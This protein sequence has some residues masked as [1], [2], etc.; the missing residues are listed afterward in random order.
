[1]S[2]TLL[3]GGKLVPYTSCLAIAHGVV[4]SYNISEI[5][6]T[7]AMGFGTLGELGEHLFTLNPILKPNPGG[8]LLYREE[9]QDAKNTEMVVL[10]GF[11]G[12]WVYKPNFWSVLTIKKISRSP[13][14]T[15]INSSANVSTPT[16]LENQADSR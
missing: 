14:R 13:G 12:D 7:A 6:P 4:D 11:G 3:T 16:Y 5:L 8:F 1:M 9:S 10:D 15:T 2:N